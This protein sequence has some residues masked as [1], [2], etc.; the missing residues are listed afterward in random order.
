MTLCQE[1]NGDNLGIFFYL[2]NS[3]GTTNSNRTKWRGL[4]RRGAGEYEAK[5]NQGS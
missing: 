1:A 2:L 4:I 5:K 3:N